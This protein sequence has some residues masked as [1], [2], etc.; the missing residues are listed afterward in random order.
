[1]KRYYNCRPR[2]NPPKQRN[3][4]KGR[5]VPHQLPPSGELSNY[6]FSNL[7][8]GN[9]MMSLVLKGMM[10]GNFDTSALMRMLL[11]QNGFKF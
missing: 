6:I 7:T 9:P 8:N 10:T 3:L 5:L 11:S 1:M 2:Y 4:K